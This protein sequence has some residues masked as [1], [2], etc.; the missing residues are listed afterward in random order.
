VKA[1]SV[2]V[3]LSSVFEMS[4]ASSSA[5]R[6]HSRIDEP[7]A[8]PTPA[9]VRTCVDDYGHVQPEP[10]GI[11]GTIDNGSGC[12]ILIRFESGADLTEFVRWRRDHGLQER[13]LTF[14]D[15]SGVARAISLILEIGDPVR[16]EP[17]VG[18]R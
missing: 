5:G 7:H 12:G 18:P 17:T 11:V 15:A 13:T 4:C 6:A 16:A 3:L 2:L 14:V 10:H 9:N 1:S 8:D